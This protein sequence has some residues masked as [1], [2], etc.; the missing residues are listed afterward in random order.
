MDVEQEVAEHYRR[1]D[2]EQ[3]ILEGLKKAGKAPEKLA[4]ADLSGVD[5]FHLGWRPATV[6]LAKDLDLTAD[7]KLLD[8][9]SGIGGPARYFAESHGTH[10]V[11]IDLTDAFVKVANS[12]THRCGLSGRVRFQQGSI[13]DL[14]FD[15]GSFDV[16]TLIHVGMNIGDKARLFRQVRRVLKPASRFA[17]YDIMRITDDELSYPMPWAAGPQTSFVETP[18]TYRTLLASAGF[19]VEQEVNRLSFVLDRWREMQERIAAEGPPPLSL[20]TLIGSTAK[21]LLGNVMAALQRGTIAP[22][23][24]IARAA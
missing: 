23:Q 21:E 10:V 5:E 20:H 11:G 13:L 18:D 19:T 24:M 4:A 3:K 6:E 17:V 9:G 7:L 16:A 22:V 2:L 14:P 1:A 12:L 8:L 15:D